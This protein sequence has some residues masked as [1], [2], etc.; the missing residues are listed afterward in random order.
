MVIKDDADFGSSISE[1]G[2]YV[3]LLVTI[4]QNAAI[5]LWFHLLWQ[6]ELS[7]RVKKWLS[8]ISLIGLH[9]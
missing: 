1:I 2:P 3:N 9:K 5:I 6:D 8:F 7:Y 4:A